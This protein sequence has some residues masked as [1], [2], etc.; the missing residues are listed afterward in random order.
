MFYVQKLCITALTFQLSFANL[1][2]LLDYFYNNASIAPYLVSCV[3]EILQLYFIFYFIRHLFR[4]LKGL[5][6]NN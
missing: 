2:N 6:S 4:F 3:I 1:I 5:A